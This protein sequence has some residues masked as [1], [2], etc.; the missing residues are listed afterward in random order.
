MAIIHMSP[1]QARRTAA[2]VRRSEATP[3]CDEGPQPVMGRTRQPDTIVGF[4]LIDEIPES[5]NASDEYDAYV[6]DW[7]P[8]QNAGIGAWVTGTD[9]IVVRDTREIG[10]YGASGHKGMC[11]IRFTSTGTR[12][13]EI[14]DMECP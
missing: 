8:S 13:G 11:I 1:Q 6:R 2:S 12:F 5:H 3:S 7:D 14:C 9:T 10:Y 4:A